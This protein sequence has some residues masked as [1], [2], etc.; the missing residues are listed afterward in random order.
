MTNDGED[1]NGLHYE[2]IRMWTNMKT[3]SSLTF[4]GYLLTFSKKVFLGVDIKH[5]NDL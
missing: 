3:R 1:G 4:I 2:Q 5:F